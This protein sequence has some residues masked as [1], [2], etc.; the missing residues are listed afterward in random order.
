MTLST[1][2]QTQA[3]SDGTRR[4]RGPSR[5]E[6][7]GVGIALA[8]GIGVVA[9]VGQSDYSPDSPSG[10]SSGDGTTSAYARPTKALDG[11][12]L[13]GYLGDHYSDRVARR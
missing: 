7:Y 2:A 5:L 8:A 4:R 6:L 13:A 11:Q 3:P 1:D 9:F 10:Y 12:T